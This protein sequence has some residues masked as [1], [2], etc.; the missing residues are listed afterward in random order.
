MQFAIEEVEKREGRID[1]P[2]SLIKETLGKRGELQ[3]FIEKYHPDKEVANLVIHLFSDNA[4]FH[5]RQV[6]KHR[7][8]Q[9]LLDRF[10]VRG[11]GSL[12]QVLVKQRQKRE[13]AP[14]EQLS[15]I[16]MEGAA[17]H[18]PRR[19]QSSIALT[20]KVSS[21]VYIHSHFLLYISFAFC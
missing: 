11:P 2:T 21:S 19:V 16:V 18:P 8:K 20:L 13:R 6:L 1:I 4:L 14:E 5:F 12:K 17:L 3:R 10:L 9:T 15:D 7:Q